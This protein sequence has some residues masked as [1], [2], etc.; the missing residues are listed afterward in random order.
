MLSSWF[1]IKMWLIFFF[2]SSHESTWPKIWK[3]CNFGKPQIVY[4]FSDSD[5]IISRIEFKRKKNLAIGFQPTYLNFEILFLMI[6]SV[7]TNLYGGTYFFLVFVGIPC[8]TIYEDV[9]RKR[10]DHWQ[11]KEWHRQSSWFTERKPT[12]SLKSERKS[13]KIGKPENRNSQ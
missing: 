8:L 5:S 3:K 6:F 13:L 7:W 11:A 2:F 1:K 9:K 10:W 12:Y 4:F